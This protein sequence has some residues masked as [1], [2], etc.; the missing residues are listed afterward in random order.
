MYNLLSKKY[1]H[2]YSTGS[3]FH[4]VFLNVSFWNCYN[5]LISISTTIVFCNWYV[6]IGGR[7]VGCQKGYPFC[8]VH[9]FHIFK[10][11]KFLFFRLIV[12]IPEMFILLLWKCCI[13]TLF[14]L[15]YY[16]PILKYSVA[17]ASFWSFTGLSTTSR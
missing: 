3:L 9:S 16:V 11:T 4:S 14:T 13:G 5:R 6:K 12:I 7:V 1:R 15:V 8:T 2:L 17:D 10:N